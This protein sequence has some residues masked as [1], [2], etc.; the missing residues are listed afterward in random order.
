MEAIDVD[1]VDRV[2]RVGDVTIHE[3]DVISIDGSTGEVFVGDL[4][5][6][7]SPVAPYLEDGLDAAVAD[8][9]EETAELV[10]AVDALLGHA[11]VTRR[12]QVRANAD[13]AEDA[14]RA[15]RLGAR[16]SGCA[17]PSTC[18]SVTGGS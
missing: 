13:T 2:A 5:V 15:R 10:R 1:A 9:D 11:D 8:V 3:G 6:V 18:S 17:A 12:L 7:P 4:P 14:A 16:A